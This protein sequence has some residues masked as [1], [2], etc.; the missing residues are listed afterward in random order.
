[1]AKGHLH[2]TTGDV[3]TL[4][5]ASP[6]ALTSA[7]LASLVTATKDLESFDSPNPGELRH[8]GATAID[9]NLR[10]DLSMWT[11]SGAGLLTLTLRKNGS[12]IPGGRAYR[13]IAEVAGAQGVSIEC[14]TTLGSQDVL[15]LWV[16]S[17]AGLDLVVGTLS[18]TAQ[19]EGA[20]AGPLAGGDWDFADLFSDLGEVLVLRDASDVD[21]SVAGALVPVEQRRVDGVTILATDRTAWVQANGLSERPQVG[22]WWLVQGSTPQAIQEVRS[23][24]VSGADVI[25]ELL[26]RANA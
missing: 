17:D 11:D 7:N 12:E 9:A 10:A 15:A 8:L 26:V 3:V 20:Y 2:A 25:Y 18:I 16:E 1:M 22:T 24:R 6:I 5:P 23:H 13:S 4:S 14:V 19:T 21:H